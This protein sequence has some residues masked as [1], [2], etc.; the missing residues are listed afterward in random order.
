MWGLIWATEV[1]MKVCF[2]Y[3]SYINFRKVPGEGDVSGVSLVSSKKIRPCWLVLTQALFPC[4]LALSLVRLSVSLKS[5]IQ[6]SDLKMN[7]NWAICIAGDRMGW[8]FVFNVHTSHISTPLA[9]AKL[10]GNLNQIYMHV[11]FSMGYPSM[12]TVFGR[13]YDLYMCTCL[14]SSCFG[15]KLVFTRY[16]FGYGYFF[17]EKSLIRM[18]VLPVYF[19]V[20]VTISF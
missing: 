4:F 9:L 6:D 5:R 3:S 2:C 7:S 15:I 20:F 17:S 18:N 16:R 11:Y 13:R 10:L 19:T 8:V 12:K 14:V 1:S